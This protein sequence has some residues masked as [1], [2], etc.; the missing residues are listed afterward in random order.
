MGLTEAKIKSRILGKS[1]DLMIF[2]PDGYEGTDLPVLYFL[3]GRTGDARI[4]QQL[5]MDITAGSMISAGKIHPLIIACPDMDNSRGINSAENYKEIR[6]KYGVVHQGRYEDYL[7][8]EVIPYVD[9]S[10]HTI[11]NRNARFIGGISA[12]GYIALHTGLRHQDLFSRIGGH[13]PAMDLSY[14]DE[15]ECY[16][17]DEA[18]WKKYDPVT[19][20]G[21]SAFRDIQVFL[22]DGKDDEGAFYRTCGK[23]ASVLRKKGI[24]VQNHLYEGRHDKEY[25]LGNMETY[26]QFYGAER[27]SCE[28]SGDQIAAALFLAWNMVTL[29]ELLSR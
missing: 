27:S 15:D 18:M 9:G 12:G 28:R 4:L 11:R 5:G 22:D 24:E 7:I 23:L 14:A 16:F 20:A 17:A 29:T 2:C 8:Q 19:I 26:L 6:G 13:M 3:H 21:N 10:C 1:M 25:V